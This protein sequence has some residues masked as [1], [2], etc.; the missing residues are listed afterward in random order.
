[1]LLYR[2][3]I[4][5]GDFE[6]GDTILNYLAPLPWQGTGYNRIAFTM[7]LQNDGELGIEQMEDR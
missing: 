7:Y 3:K 1:M 6:S 2:S 5:D 4:K